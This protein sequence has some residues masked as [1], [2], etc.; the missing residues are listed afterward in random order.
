MGNVINFRPRSRPSRQLAKQWLSLNISAFPNMQEDIGPNLFYGW[1]FVRGHDGVV[2]F[3][4]CIE[5]GISKQE[6]YEFLKSE[7]S[8]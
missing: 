3:A 8:K 2:Y 6:F 7:C 1:R 4:N 5:P